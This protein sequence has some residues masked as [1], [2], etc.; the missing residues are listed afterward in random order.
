MKDKLEEVIALSEAKKLVAIPSSDKVLELIS[1]RTFDKHDIKAIRRFQAIIAEEF[2]IQLVVI[3]GGYG[4]TKIIFHLDKASPDEVRIMI[5]E[6]LESSMFREAALNVDFEIAIVRNPDARIVLKNG[7]SESLSNNQ[8]ILLFCSYSHKDEEYKET[9]NN[10]L[11]A[12]KRQGYIKVWHDR[13]ITAGEEW[14]D[15]IDKNLEDASVVLLLISSDFLA[16]DYCYSKEMTRALERHKLKD[17]VV[18]PIIVRPVD[19]QQAP[20]AKLQA[21]PK[22]GRAIT[23]WDNEDEAWSLVAKEIRTRILKMYN[24]NGAYRTASR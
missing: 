24:S 19:W 4:C 15:T 2:K 8:G 22:D 20:F 16:S 13:L 11:S 23:L 3:G 12:L 5:Q 9:L 1:Y 14:E 17:A 21:I 7:K 18:I 6:L 10:H